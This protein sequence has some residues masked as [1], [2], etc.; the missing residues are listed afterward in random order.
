MNICSKSKLPQISLQKS[1]E[2]LR[3]IKPCVNDYYSI[4]ANHYIHAGSIGLNHFHLLLS[5]LINDLDGISLTEVNL[6]Y[7]VV[8]FKGHGKDKNSDRSYRTISTCPVIAKA[9]DLYIRDLNISTWNLNQSE[10]Q[11]QGEGSSHELESLL[12]TECIQ[13]SLHHLKQPLYVL[14]LDAR[15]AF[16]VVL[17]ELMIKNLYF[18]GTDGEILLYLSNRLSN[19]KTFLDWNGQLMG[20]ILDEQGLEQGGVQSSDFYKIFGKEQLVTAQESSLGVPLGPVTVSGIG[21]ADDTAL[22]SNNLQQL[23]FLLHLATVFCSKYH[24]KLCSDKTKLQVYH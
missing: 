11:F 24:V 12:V 13:H 21:L 8:L 17:K 20:P 7:A 18:S 9:L 2:I 3:R 6:V 10:C 5:S 16:D 19:R 15:S 14:Y 4:T 1:S 22:L 23:Y